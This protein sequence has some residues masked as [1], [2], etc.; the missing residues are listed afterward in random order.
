VDT[1]LKGKNV[2]SYHRAGI[3]DVSILLSR[4]LADWAQ[5]IQISARRFLLWT[6]LAVDVAPVDAHAHGGT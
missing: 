6:S 4:T 2:S 5:T 1:Y 3:D